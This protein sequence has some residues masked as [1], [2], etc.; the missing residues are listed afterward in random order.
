GIPRQA[1]EKNLPVKGTDLRAQDI[2]DPASICPW[3]PDMYGVDLSKPGAQAY[4]DSVFELIAS[5]DVGP[6]CDWA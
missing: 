6:C 3:N 1:V 2:A 5:W 4:Y